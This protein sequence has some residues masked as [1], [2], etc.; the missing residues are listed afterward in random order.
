MAWIG[1]LSN[2]LSHRA[3][4]V[5]GCAIYFCVFAAW[6]VLDD[7]VA[8]ALLKLVLGVGF[9]LTYVGA[10]VIVDDLVPERLRATGQS[11]SKAVSFALAP[12]LGTLGGGWLYD[13]FGPSTMFVAATV[14]AAIAAAVGWLSISQPETRPIEAEV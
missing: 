10:V 8:I 13:Q 14:S 12:I 5:V 11:L 2:V 9:A 4:Y 1:R 7:P 6:G 3:I